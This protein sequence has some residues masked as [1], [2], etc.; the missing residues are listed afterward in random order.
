MADRLGAEQNLKNDPLLLGIRLN[1]WVPVGRARRAWQIAAL[2][3]V[4]IGWREA[5]P[6]R[7]LRKRETLHVANIRVTTAADQVAPRCHP[8]LDQRQFPRTIR[9]LP[10]RVLCALHRQGVLSVRE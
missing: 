4:T 9:F 6:H 5:F 1:R 2:N 8:A 7:P 10:V 3:K